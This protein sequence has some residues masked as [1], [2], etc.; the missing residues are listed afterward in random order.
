MTSIEGNLVASDKVKL[1][2][3]SWKP[4]GP[5]LATVTFIHG[6]GEHSGR[7]EHVFSK[8]AENGIA[9]NA[10]DQ[11][12]FGKSSGPRAYSPSLDQTMKD[13]AMVAAS[14]NP[15][16]PHFIM[17]HSFGGCL[18]LHYTLKKSE[19]DPTGCIITS[20][21][22]KP[23]FKV[24]DAKYLVGSFI[25]KFWSTL[26][27]DNGLNPTHISRDEA[28]VALY[29][30]D[31]LN[32][33]KVSVGLGK[34][35][36]PKAEQLL[37]LA[38]TYTL[39]LLLIHGADDMITSAKA[40]Q[41]FFDRCQSQD[42]T[43]KLWENMYHEV[44]NEKDKDQVIQMI[45]DW[46]K[47]RLQAPQSQAIPTGQDQSIPQPVIAPSIPVE[48]PPVHV[49]PSRQEDQQKPV[50]EPPKPHEEPHKALEE[51]PKP[52]DEPPKHAEEPPKP[53]EE[54]P[55]Q[56]D[57]P[58]KPVEE[59]PKPVDEPP[60]PVEEAPKPIEEAP[61][62]VDEPPKTVEEPPK[63]VEESAKPVEEAPK[64]IEEAPKQV[65][66]P[67]KP[68]EEAPKIEEN[69]PNEE[70]KPKNKKKGKKKGKRN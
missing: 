48:E 44:L 28:A 63:P 58:P 13:V 3:R 23:A 24:S 61:K 66:E 47:P 49:E 14:A 52:V 12:G 59:P 68:V 10:Y 34:W 8:F 36:I 51:P 60:K 57:E 1:F 7:Y 41:S 11:R 62:Q 25:S 53:V 6:L 19:R 26:T 22:I 5:T 67:P 45:I 42:K 50:E 4:A 32:T 9:V 56:V 18:A 70:S 55:K 15:N 21:L 29:K 46:I 65:D 17:G 20:P 40:S 38:P 16:L 39:P 69:K 30:E 31:P 2:T 43:L 35:M 27:V 37:N 54:P 64:P 33:A